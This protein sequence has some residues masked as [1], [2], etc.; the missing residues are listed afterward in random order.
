MLWTGR[1]ATVITAHCSVERSEALFQALGRP[2]GI[3]EG[4]EAVHMQ[5][6]GRP[7][8]RD[9]HS[10]SLIAEGSAPR[11]DPAQAWR[12]GSHPGSEPQA[13]PGPSQSPRW[14][15]ASA[16]P[17]TPAAMTKRSSPLPAAEKTVSDSMQA[18]R[19]TLRDLPRC[20]FSSSSFHK[21]LP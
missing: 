12:R 8:A 1:Y 10:F 18:W 3:E 15:V 21:P 16:P 6:H 19:S 4:P 2:H 14:P 9:L 20:Q 7:V 13:P 5:Q 17:E 11:A